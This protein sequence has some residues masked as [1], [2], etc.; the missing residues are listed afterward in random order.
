MKWVWAI[1]LCLSIGCEVIE[2]P[3]DNGELALAYGT[4]VEEGLGFSALEQPV[5]QE[6]KPSP[7]YG[8]TVDDSLI[9]L[10]I[11]EVDR[12]TTL[13]FSTDSCEY[14]IDAEGLKSLT[15]KELSRLTAVINLFLAGAW[16]TD[17]FANAIFE[18]FIPERFKVK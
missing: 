10:E 11:V 3:K 2:K 18:T 14:S 12:D 17:D 5:N 15:D 16:Y 7:A 9:I 13:S 8:T 4:T 6:E 1:L